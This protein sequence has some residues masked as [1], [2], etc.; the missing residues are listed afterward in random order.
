MNEI[1]SNNHSVF[2]NEAGYPYLA[3]LLTPAAYS[4]LF[5]LVDTNTYTHCLPSFLAQ[6]ATDVPFEIIEFEAGESN[7]NLETCMHIW[8]AMTELNGDRKSAVIN[9]G[10]GV[11]TDLGG[12][13]A[14][15]FKRGIDYINVPTTLLAMVDAS[16]GGKN[17]IDLGHLK[18]QIGTI[19]N[20]KVVFINT[21][22]LETLPQL[23]M[24]S[25]FAEM[26]KHGLIL[27]RDYW[28]Q[29]KDLS[30]LT[31]DDLDLLIYKSVVLKNKVVTE[32]Q[33]ETGIRKAL[34][35]GHTLGHAIESHCMISEH[36]PTLLHGEAVA[37]GMLLESY[38]SLEM[39][40]LTIEEYTEI[41]NV[42]LGMYE[43]PEFTADDIQNITDLLIYDKKN[44]FGIIQFC[45]LNGIG[46]V[47]I[48]QQ[49]DN[50]LIFKAFK[51]YKK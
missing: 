43:F 10:G 30:Q 44:E 17:G 3:Q 7:K 33:T 25:G 11:V 49:V 22:F 16:V 32:D 37:V 26:L 9:L 29:F 6:L 4:K 13:I 50:K 35:F 47:K 46:D 36:L 2:F 41:K 1:S 14:S 8:Q 48:N 40:L 51:D 5:I 42:L 34:N 18:N 28:N 45:L 12:F 15:T 19:T 38:I 31:T 27:D 23:E 21:Q 39:N 20:P 24:R